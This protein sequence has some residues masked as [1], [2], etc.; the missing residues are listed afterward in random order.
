MNKICDTEIAKTIVFSNSYFPN[1]LKA[2]KNTKSQINYIKKRLAKIEELKEEDMDE[3]LSMQL[4][5]LSSFSD[6]LLYEFENDYKAL[7]ALKSKMWKQILSKKI[8]S[9]R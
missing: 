2:L 6:E 7:G 4:E 8:R 5:E 1:I 9:I 3:C